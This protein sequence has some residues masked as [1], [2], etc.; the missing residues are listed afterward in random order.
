[1]LSTRQDVQVRPAADTDLDGIVSLFMEIHPALRT[2]PDFARR[3]Y[4][5]K[6]FDLT[7]R[8]TGYPSAFVAEDGEGIAGFIGCLPFVIRYN[9]N[10]SPAAW[11]ADWRLSSRVRGHG[12][13]RALL[14]TAIETI[15][16]VACVSGSPDAERIY[17]EVG[18]QSWL[19]ARS[20]LLVRHALAYEWPERDGARK[21]RGLYR[22]AQHAARRHIMLRPRPRSRQLLV[23]EPCTA[24]DQVEL[25][26]RRIRYNGLLRR[27]GYLAWLSRS[28]AAS[29]RLYLLRAQG[30]ES[31][32]EAIGYAFVQLD[33]DALKR[34]RGRIL[35]LLL[36]PEASDLMTDAYRVIAGLLCRSGRVDY[37][38]ATTPVDDSIA[39]YHAGFTPR[40]HSRLW[41]KSRDE[42]YDDADKWMV[43][44]VDKD[45]AFR[46]SGI[47]P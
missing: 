21:I 4:H 24:E 46:G 26:L 47:A 43:S 1:M 6:H 10:S 17:A 38:D 28:P 42:R 14:Q 11:I 35:D 30:G 23:A 5:W 2:D 45:D 27:P 41:I 22:S 16:T 15:P 34:R 33:R 19:A 29:T 25:V 12:L 31:E 44:L 7:G 8:A 36:V 40:S 13:G 18:F 37:I 20:W 9:G 3:Y 32:G 39:V